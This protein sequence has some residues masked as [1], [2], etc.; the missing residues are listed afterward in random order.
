M[1]DFMKKE[2]KAMKITVPANPQPV[3]IEIARTALIVVDMQ[4]AFCSSEGMFDLKGSLDRPKVEKVIDVDK[5]VIQACRGRGI[6]IIYLRM[7]YRPDLADA[8]GPE[9][10][11]YWKERGISLMREKPEMK[12]HGLIVG[13]WNWEVID[14][15][16]P[17]SE[18]ILVNKN[19]FS[20]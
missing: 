18:D 17:Q 14:D 5:K 6:K 13:N 9:S 2:I 3:K 8:G 19:R 11:N 15:L 10:P 16:K 7:G 1:K 20:G 4:N 12:E